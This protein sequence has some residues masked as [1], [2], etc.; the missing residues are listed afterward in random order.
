MITDRIQSR[1][2][3]RAI[4]L[5]G[6]QF[7]AVFKSAVTNGLHRRG[8][9]KCRQALAVVERMI[10]NPAHITVGVYYDLLDIQ[11]TVKGMVANDLQAIAQ[12]NAH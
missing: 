11:T 6:S 5:N 8:H 2:P 12:S 7:L 3:V 1:N 10:S 9:L 4:Q